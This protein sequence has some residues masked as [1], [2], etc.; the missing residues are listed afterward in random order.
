MSAAHTLRA[1]QAPIKET[2][3]TDPSSALVTLSSTGSLSASS[4]TCKL[5]T[6]AAAQQA[7][8]RVAGLHPKAGGSDPLISGELCSGDTLLDA[9]VACSGV[10]L[11]A[12]A[13][14]L[15]LPI[16]S[17][18]VTAEGDLDFRG[19]LGVDREAP[20]GITDIRLRFEVEFGVKED[21]SEVDQG[22]VEA[23]GKLT[24]RYCVVLQTLV[25]K[26]EIGVVVVGK[27]GREDG[28]EREVVRGSKC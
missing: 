26:P 2:Y 25:K 16:Q 4:I 18:T 6:G 10:T 22:D 27:V 15:K 8:S 23:L 20:V 11:S 21:G 19:T 9:L 12:V 13:T 1:K 5:S 24:E 14:A 7:S 3:R 28:V 17:G